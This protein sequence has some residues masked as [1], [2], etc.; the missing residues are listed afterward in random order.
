MNDEG[1]QPR[2]IYHKHVWS[3]FRDLLKNPLHEAPA[4]RFCRIDATRCEL[5][6]FDGQHKTVAAMLAG[7]T[8]LVFK[9]YLDLSPQEANVLVN[10]IQDQL[11]KQGLNVVESVNKFSSEFNAEWD[12]YIQQVEEDNAS[13][14]GFI[15]ALERGSRNRAKKALKAKL[16]A[17][18]FAEEGNLELAEW[19]TDRR[20]EDGVTKKAYCDKFLL[21]LITPAPLRTPGI[22]GVRQRLRE[23]IAATRI[24][25]FMLDNYWLPPVDAAS[26]SDANLLRSSRLRKQVS[27]NMTAELFRFLYQM[28]G[29]PVENDQEVFL[30]KE[31]NQEEWIRVEQG[32]RSYFD[33]PYWTAARTLPDRPAVAMADN[34]LERNESSQFNFIRENRLFASFPYALV[35]NLP[36]QWGRQ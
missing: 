4:L 5:R 11:T 27:L 26:S 28:V 8:S 12:E 16:Q 9:I 2:R 22:E 1:V 15:Q 18:F 7:Y 31:L 25:R 14:N 19:L 21:R 10:S 35:Q 23:R 32:V 33:H 24:S 13:E 17:D 3:L 36:P 30:L 34:H 29:T 6:M 20:A